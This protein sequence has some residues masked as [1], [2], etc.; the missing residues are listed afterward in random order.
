MEFEIQ[1]RYPAPVVAILAQYTDPTLYE[2]LVGLPKLGGAEVLDRVEAGDRVTLRVRY[3]FEGDLPSAAT[4]VIDRNKLT[5]VDETVYDLA[6]ATA[7]TRF[8]P[9]HYPDRMQATATSR[10]VADGADDRSVRRID[11]DLRVHVFL[12]AGKVE[13]A[14]VSGLREYLAAEA[15]AIAAR[16]TPSD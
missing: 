14:I 16:V 13:N 12:V 5:W 2:T 10:F 6:S 11:G 8:L 1:Q 3:R 4:A 7:T 9:D 15:A